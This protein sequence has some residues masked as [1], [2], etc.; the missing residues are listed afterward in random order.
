VISTSLASS[1]QLKTINEKQ[2]KSKRKEM[3]SKEDINEVNEN[4]SDTTTLI[5]H[6]EFYVFLPQ[7]VEG[8]ITDT[9]R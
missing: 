8:K 1:V 3:K 2:M 9:F 7:K 4:E 5:L 6:S